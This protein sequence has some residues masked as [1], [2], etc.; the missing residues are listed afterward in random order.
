MIEALKN[1]MAYGSILSSLSS[2]QV[3]TADC[4]RKE[5]KNNFIT[6]I[7][8]RLLGIPHL[9]LRIRANTILKFL[10][11]QKSDVVLDAGCG[12]GL[13]LLTLS[14]K[15][16]RGFGV[17]TDLK[18]IRE[19]ERSVKE[20]S[21]KNIFFFNTDATRL[22]FPDLFF[23]KIVCSEVLEHIDDDQKLINEF[24][25]TLKHGGTLVISTPSL[26]RINFEHKEEFNHKRIGYSLEQLKKMLTNCDFYVEE[27]LPY[28]LFFGKISWR[29]NRKILSKSILNALTFYP[30]MLFAY[31]DK[32]L[33]HNLSTD[34]IGYI[35]KLRKSIRE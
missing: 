25:R 8:I 4:I 13:Y 9:G 17:D 22:N 5:I 15:I 24:F 2:F 7:A 23:D 12:I 1:K 6:K 14:S 10:S 20:L 29:L 32:F 28:C 3:S 31:L 35:I 11:P 30:L 16:R 19:A 21:I 33:S 26:S 27:I 18:K 34:C